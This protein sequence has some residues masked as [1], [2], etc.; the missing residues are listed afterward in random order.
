MKFTE[1][2]KKTLE[3]FAKIN[4]GLLFLEGK[5]QKTMT[6]TKT[7]VAEAEID[8]DIPKEFGVYKLAN[9][10]SFLSL[11]NDPTVNFEDTHLT[12]TEG[13]FTASYTFCS[14]D[15]IKH[16]PKDKSITLK[17]V[18]VE[19][20]LT[21]SDLSHLLKSASV[22]G[23]PNMIVQGDGETISVVVTD[24]GNTS[25]DKIS[26]RIADTTETFKYIINIDSLKM[27]EDDYDVKASSAGIIQFDSKNLGAKY[28][29]V[30]D[31]K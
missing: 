11:F 27:M 18:D 10:L 29:V 9:F 15:V 13:D 23:A 5:K 6:P 25:S 16:P 14:P 7:V 8:M 31:A 20:T 3:N 2:T 17:S 19:F 1:N 26:K 24:A 12:L 22:I 4:E 21:K 28:W 30:V